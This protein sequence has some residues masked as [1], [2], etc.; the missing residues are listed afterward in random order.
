MQVSVMCK[1]LYEDWLHLRK[2]CRDTW[3]VRRFTIG[4]SSRSSWFEE[5]CGM[6]WRFGLLGVVVLDDAVMYW[7]E[8]GSVPGG[9]FSRVEED[10]I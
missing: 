6:V 7:T 4:K 8:E 3:P 2:S 5:D 10:I 1:I 9:S